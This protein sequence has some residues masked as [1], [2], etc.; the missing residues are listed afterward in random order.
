MTA[1]VKRMYAKEK[2]MGIGNKILSY[3]ECQAVDMG[4]KSLRLDPPH[5]QHESSFI[6]QKKWI[7]KITANYEYEGGRFY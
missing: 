6:L 3:L 7:Y 1:E 4:Y 2:G 5:R